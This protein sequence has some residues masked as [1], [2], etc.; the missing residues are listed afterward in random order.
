MGEAGQGSWPE[1]QRL[2]QRG[3]GGRSSFQLRLG[4]L[5]VVPPRSA[6]W[7]RSLS[8]GLFSKMSSG[9]RLLS[10][11]VGSCAQRC[12]G[13]EFKSDRADP[14]GNRRWRIWREEDS[15]GSSS[16]PARF[17]DPAIFILIS[18]QLQ[19]P[20]G[21][22]PAFP[23]KN[24]ASRTQGQPSG[25][26]GCWGPC[27]LASSSS[28]PACSGWRQA[29]PDWVGLFWV[30][31]CVSTPSSRELKAGARHLGTGPRSLGAAHGGQGAASEE[32]PQHAE[33]GEK[34][35]AIPKALIY[36]RLRELIIARGP[37]RRAEGLTVA[38]LAAGTAA[39]T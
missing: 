9:R 31:F 25:Q 13:W 39:A 34:F 18:H 3:A 24:C 5:R 37:G 16:F 6:Q 23:L 10:E 12:R 2:N 27:G 14:P 22:G 32:A 33:K 30:Y 15:P 11:R 35:T 21:R 8:C 17:Q 28:G 19:P 26:G 20:S 29:G 1:T 36:R 4:G 38:H 7:P